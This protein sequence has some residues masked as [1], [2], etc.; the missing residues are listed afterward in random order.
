MRIF[1]QQFSSLKPRF[2]RQLKVGFIMSLLGL[3]T[4]VPP[5]QALTAAVLGMHVL[6]PQEL[7]D[8]KTLVDAKPQD[9]Q[10]HYV[11]IPLSLDDLSKQSEWQTF[12]NNAKDQHMIPIVRLVTRFGGKSWNIPTRK[13]IVAMT[14]FL[15]QLTWPTDQKYVIVFNEVNHANEWGGQLDPAGYADVLQFTTNWLHAT[16]PQ[17]VVMPAAMDLA[18][19]N[20][21]DPDGAPTQTAFSYLEAMH[22][23]N[24]DV[25]GSI[26]YWNSHS[27]PNPG[28]SSAPTR[29]A[30]NSLR[31]F[32]FELDWLKAQTGRDFQVFITE[33]GWV[34]SPQ[35]HR[36]L[37][38]YYTYALK[39]VWSDP[40]VIAV[41]PFVLRGDPG[42]FATFGFL[43]RNNKPT[44]QYQA[45]RQAL[46]RAAGT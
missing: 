41:T 31:G 14:D 43:D 15:S 1:S 9:Q 40:R 34:D 37:S 17:F 12:F 23:S 11:T 45:L 19:P 21:H 18:A 22:T 3:L 38:D 32:T 4:F 20:G 36:W 8:A 39:N 26:D 5:A 28:F 6:Q 29:T 35:T 2:H 42:P 13:D 44:Y 27:Y 24:P 25:F 16:D 7:N 30:I 46:E 10:W 33:T